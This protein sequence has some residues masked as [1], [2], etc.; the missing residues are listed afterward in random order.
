[1]PTFSVA[2]GYG[3]LG[4]NGPLNSGIVAVIVAAFMASAET[5]RSRA[6][7]IV[8]CVIVVFLSCSIMRGGPEH[9]NPSVVLVRYFVVL[10]K[11]VWPLLGVVVLDAYAHAGF[12]AHRLRKILA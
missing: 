8:L 3:P 7:A 6:H 12:H 9:T 5:A 1:M 2:P 11:K 10:G 4:L